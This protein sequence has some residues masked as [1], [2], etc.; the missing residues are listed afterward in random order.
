MTTL[1]L[2]VQSTS[3]LVATLLTGL[4][5]GILFTWANAVTTGLARLDAFGYLRA[6]QQMN[7][8]ILNPAF[9]IVF[10]GP[11][12]V[13]LVVAFLYRSQSNLLFVL[14][15]IAAAL[16][17]LG[18]LLPTGAGNIPLNNIL[19]KADLAKISLQD[20]Q[21]LRTQF[22]VRWNNFHLI[23]T[24]CATLSFGLLLLITQLTKQP[25]I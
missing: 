16:Y 15:L 3:L 10:V 5:A 21:S 8:T 6:F 2:S 13:S 11:G 14:L 17:F 20:A 25:G 22:E 1:N 24:I 23:R 18:V 9:F 7:R 12:F 4:S 19:E